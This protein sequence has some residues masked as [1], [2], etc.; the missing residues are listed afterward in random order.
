MVVESK[1]L[2]HRR[3]SSI[4]PWKKCFPLSEPIFNAEVLL[5]KF[6]EAEWVGDNGLHIGCHQYLAE[7]DID[8]VC[9]ALKESLSL[10][11]K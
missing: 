7:E 2:F 5:V 11:T 4:F 10:L 9:K 3:T 1:A 8:R 6:P